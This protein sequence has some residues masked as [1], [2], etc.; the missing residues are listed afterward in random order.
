MTPIPVLGVLAYMRGD[1]LTRMVESIDHPVEKLVVVLNGVDESIVKAADR[2]RALFPDVIIYNPG[3]DQPKPVN[4]GCSGGWNWIL[5]NHMRDW[6]LLVG[7]DIQFAK[8]DLDRIAA[9]YDKHKNDNPP[10]GLV[11]T[12]YGWHACGVTKAGV[13]A[14]GYFDENLYP[15]Y[16]EDVDFNWRHYLARKIGRLS[17]PPDGECVIYAHHEGSASSR[18]L[19]GPQFERLCKSF[20]RNVEYHIRKWGGAQCHEIYDHPFNDP[21]LDIRD[22]TLEPGRWELNSLT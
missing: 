6:V 18:S 8:G 16:Q 13:E 9:H 10:M 7:S 20:E 2:I 5:K 3:L 19:P 21:A 14:M 22:W 11:T 15:A 4:L 1:L 12:N 17:Y